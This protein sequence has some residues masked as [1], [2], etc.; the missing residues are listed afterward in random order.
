MIKINLLPPEKRRKQIPLKRFIT[1]VM[2]SFVIVWVGI[3]FFMLFQAAILQDSI[4]SA[5]ESYQLM[6][7]SI[8]KKEITEKKQQVI[9]KKNA[10][11]TGIS[12]NINAEYAVLSNISEL[13]T[14]NVWL[15]EFHMNEKKV[16]RIKGN[17]SS[18]L[19]LATFLN[20]FE[21]NKA[22]TE[23]SL[24]SANVTKVSNQEITQFE[25]TAKF[26]EL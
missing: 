4:L 21:N 23:V 16:V 5:K 13:V 11:V 14:A 24:T 20:R 10:V 8:E 6:T 25:V 15:T 18:Y 3:Y 26:K 22:F 17:A 19:Q 12:K 1:I 2:S 7:K 9:N